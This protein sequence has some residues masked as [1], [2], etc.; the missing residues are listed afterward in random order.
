MSLFKSKLKKAVSL[1][2]MYWKVVYWKSRAHA[3]ELEFRIYAIQKNRKKRTEYLLHLEEKLSK[4]ANEIREMQLILEHRN[5]ER[6]ALNILVACDGP[7]NR[8]YMDD[9]SS[10]D[11]K[12]VKLVV[13]NAERLI[14]WWNRG[15]QKGHEEYM[16]RWKETMKRLREK[17]LAN[18]PE[19]KQE[20]E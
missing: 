7:C 18:H 12:T 9:P 6:K 17:W 20:G 2:S 11:E 10:V 14:H 4:Q 16:L 13:R 15:G 5:K 1:A 8:A 3:A 19:D